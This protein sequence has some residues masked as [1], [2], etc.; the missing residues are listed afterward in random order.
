MRF[1]CIQLD[2]KY[3]SGDLAF[4]TKLLKS[5]NYHPSIQGGYN[6]IELNARQFAEIGILKKGTDSKAFADRVYLFQKNVPDSYTA[7]D[8]ANV[9]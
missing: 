4:N 3:V 8:V 7:A 6:A 1:R 9:K 2:K 5:Y